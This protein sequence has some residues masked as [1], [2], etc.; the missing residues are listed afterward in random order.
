MGDLALKKKIGH[1]CSQ[2]ENGEMGRRN[3]I[4]EEE[5]RIIQWERQEGGINNT[6]DV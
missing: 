3:L 2:G 1:R 5:R 6:K 4:G